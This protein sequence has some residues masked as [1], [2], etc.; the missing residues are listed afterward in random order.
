MSRQDGV[1]AAP[2]VET[3]AFV[4]FVTRIIGAAGRRVGQG[5][6]A[7]LA[8][9]AGLRTQLDETITAAVRELHDGPYQYSWSQIGTALGITKQAAQQRYGDP[10]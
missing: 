10:S 7:A 4:G 6:I 2:D 3:P 1:D 9:L 5:D 8:D